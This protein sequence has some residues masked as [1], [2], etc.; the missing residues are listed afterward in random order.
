MKTRI[1]ALD[2]ASTTGVADGYIGD[3]PALSVWRLREDADDEPHDIARRAARLLWLRIS[4]E[5]PDVLAIEMPVPPHSAKGHTNA[6]TTV[7]TQ[8]LY[9]LYT[10]IAGAAR[11]KIVPAHIRRW[12]KAILGQGNLKG[13]IAKARMMAMCRRMS[14]DPPDHNA[15]E[16]AGIWMW[17]AGTNQEALLRRAPA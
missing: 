14:L 10:G 8:G 15:A 9:F 5:K 3:T 1:L 12:R 13:D 7:I 17:A 11:I 2:P 6:A 4:H 16:A